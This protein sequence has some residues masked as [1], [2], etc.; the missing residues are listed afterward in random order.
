ML[1]E[2]PHGALEEGSAEWLQVASRYVLHRE[3]WTLSPLLLRLLCC[4]ASTCAVAGLPPDDV[5]SMSTAEIEAATSGDVVIALVQSGGHA[6][7]DF[8]RAAAALCQQATS[9]AQQ[10]QQL[11]EAGLHAK[12]F[13][14][15]WLGPHDPPDAA[16]ARYVMADDV[17]QGGAIGLV[18]GGWPLDKPQQLH[19][20]PRHAPVYAWQPMPSALD[21]AMS[22]PAPATPPVA[23]VNG[24]DPTHQSNSL[25]ETPN[26]AVG[27]ATEDQPV[28]LM[29]TDAF[30][31]PPQQPLTPPPA[32]R[33]KGKGRSKGV[34]MKLVAAGGGAA[35][36]VLQQPSTTP[37]PPAPMTPPLAK[38]QSV[39]LRSLKEAQS[40]AAAQQGV[41]PLGGG[42]VSGRKKGKGKIRKG[43]ALSLSEMQADAADSQAARWAAAPPTAPKPTA[44]PSLASIAAAQAAES[45]ARVK[46]A[47]DIARKR[48]ATG[49][50]SS[51]VSTAGSQQRGT[52][53]L[54]GADD[55]VSLAQVA[56]QQAE[57]ERRAAAARE[58]AAAEAA[59][60]AAEAEQIRLATEMSLQEHR[61][62]VAFFES[63]QGGAEPQ[64]G[65]VPSRGRHTRRGRGGGQA[66]AGQGG[67]G[68]ARGG[69][70]GRGAGAKRPA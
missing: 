66:K 64:S 8:V 3:R 44:A 31:P 49:R 39:P 12:A 40:L 14:H 26:S 35:H 36:A 4:A 21:A 58:A 33:S 56:K 25:P 43:R 52:W 13:M 65:H 57:A 17:V 9:A 46:A 30:E 27:G 15:S 28:S 10:L 23:P 53:R 34:K 42:G 22:P 38:A 54:G 11:H 7:C 59:L 19:T 63:L 68:G 20:P 29:S 6:L 45:A 55:K 37:P 41:L 61:A 16:A 32:P 1:Q 69:R 18:G 47:H 60:D 50:G 70:R 2:E 67:R 5:A 48:L 24:A 62:E 51:G